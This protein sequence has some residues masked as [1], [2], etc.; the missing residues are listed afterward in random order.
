M[1][2]GPIAIFDLDR[3]MHA[4]SG[5]GV[6]SRHAFRAKFISGER[7]ARSFVHDFVF[8]KGASTDG[9]INSIAEFA[10][11]MGG[12]KSLHELEPIIEATTTEIFCREDAELE[13]A[14]I[15]ED[16]IFSEGA[17]ENDVPNKTSILT[18]DPR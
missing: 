8:R 5:L 17:E 2:P 6:L 10:L 12:G 1:I 7:M 15:S 18:P 3:T 11:E 14:I 13:G 4:G 16:T 9:H